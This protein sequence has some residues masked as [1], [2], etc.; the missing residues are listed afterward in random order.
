MSYEQRKKDHLRGQRSHH[1]GFQ[2][3]S[4]C[5][6]HRITDVVPVAVGQQNHIRGQFIGRD[7]CLAVAGD[8]RVDE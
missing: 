2:A 5:N 1:G 3:G 7:F 6:A 8:E 4:G